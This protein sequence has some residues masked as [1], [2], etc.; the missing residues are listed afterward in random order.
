MS[1]RPFT[2]GERL[3]AVALQRSVLPGRAASADYR[4]TSSPRVEE[5]AGGAKRSRSALFWAALGASL[6]GWIGERL[7]AGVGDTWGAVMGALPFWFLE[8]HRTK[9]SPADVRPQQPGAKGA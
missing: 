6:G 1:F 4:K 9:G 2:D 7:A 3:Q 8:R 5:N